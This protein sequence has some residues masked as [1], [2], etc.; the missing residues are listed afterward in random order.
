[1]SDINLIQLS[2]YVRPAIVEQKYKGYVLNGKNNEF[3]QY[4]IDRYNGS[5]TNASII[6][7][8]ID[9]IYG[10][11]LGATN[12]NTNLKDWTYL[13]TI[14]K[15]TELK[16]II[17][18]F[19]LF[20][21][22][23]IQCIKTKG[24]KDLATLAHIPTNLVVPSIENE[25]GEIESYWYS[26]NWSKITQNPPKEYPAF[27]TSKE[28]I[29]IFRIKPYKAGKDYFA[30]PDY[31]SGLPY[32]EMEEEIA[33]LNINSIKNGLSAGYII[34]V[35]DGKSL[36][37]EEKAEFE[38]KIKQKLT[39]SPNASRFILSFNG[40]DAEINITPFPV[41]EQIHKQWEFLTEEAKQQLLTAHRATSPSIVGIVSSS[42]FSN[43]A[44]E[45]DTAEAQL[46]KRV[47]A[48]KQSH[49]IDALQD[50][51][52]FYNINLDLKFIQLTEPT[53]A[54]PTKL[55]KEGKQNP[56]SEEQI[57]RLIEMGEVIDENEWEIIEDERCDAITLK[58]SQLNNIFQLASTPKTSDKKSEQDTSL[59]KIRYKYAGNPLPERM[60]CKKV[61]FS[62]K[63]YRAEDLNANYNYN[64]EFAPSGQSS[65]NIFLFKGGVNCKHWWQRVIYMKK[66]NEQ[67]SVNDARRMILELDPKDRKDAMWQSND[68]RVAKVAE[69]ANNWW[70]LK[71]NYR[72]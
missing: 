37:T 5:P 4:I 49:I 66:G 6:N 41:N 39:G 26:K 20:G 63:V 45:M 33:N 11:G 7:S 72:S 46:V 65:Y 19:Q 31:L 68:D 25:D 29:E 21:E 53:Q 23:T 44:D 1:M 71:P 56:F 42:G 17:S 52:T 3:Y 12:S 60:F 32:A 8:Y 59:F 61:M 43:T 62:N 36:S 64:E 38:K 70:S 30:D 18:D 58:E 34:N 22:A 69:P 27:G 13:K 54:Q 15:D 50:I 57:D 40:R 67:I 10:K 47:I 35:P 55:S 48:P 14:L 16:K 9:L 2:N 28:N 24:G 51:L